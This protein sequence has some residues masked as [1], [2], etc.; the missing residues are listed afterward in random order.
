MRGYTPAETC[1]LLLFTRLGEDPPLTARNYRSLR[2]MLEALGEA[3]GDPDRELDL[4][5]LLRLGQTRQEA[6]AILRRLERT[7]ELEAY[8]GYL[9]RRGITA[10]TR[11]SPAYPIRLR[12]VLGEKAPMVLL[13]A[14]NLDLMQRECVSLVGSRA[15]REPGRRF[16]AALGRR[17]AEQGLPCLPET[18]LLWNEALKTLHVITGITRLI[19]KIF[20]TMLN[21]MIFPSSWLY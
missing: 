6:E 17:T 5:E 3:D 4:P 21:Y 14:G 9:R 15:L 7:E 19:R 11:L 8:L 16:A 2:R 18:G 1:M 10:V 20:R 13:C 12:Q